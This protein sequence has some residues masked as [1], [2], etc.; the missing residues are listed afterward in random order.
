[1]AFPGDGI[2]P[3]VMTHALKALKALGEKHSVQLKVIETQC[4]SGYFKKTGR[5]WPEG[6]LD[7]CKEADAIILGAVGIPGVVMPDGKTPSSKVIFGLRLGLDLYANVR[8]VKLYPNVK[9]DVS[10]H[11]RR[12]W[13]SVDFVIVRE[14]TEGAYAPV[15]GNL[16]VGN[17][18]ERRVDNRLITRKGSERIARF[19]FG[20]ARTRNGSPLDG[21]RRVTCV[22]KSNVLA[23]CRLFRG[24][25]DE[26]ATHYPGIE[27]DYAYID[28]ITQWLVRRP[29]FYDV[30][31][32]TNLFGDILSDLAATLQGGM[33]MAPSAN[34]GDKHAM[35]E[36]VHGSAPDIAGKDVANPIAMLLSTK[37]MLEWL[38]E[39]KNDEALLECATDIESAVVKVLNEG[40]VLTPDLG[41]KSSCTDLGQEITKRLK[42]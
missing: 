38:G 37:M 8:P 23:G 31:V 17:Q 19:A 11:F 1:M 39:R 33:G 12:I 34:I 2:G 36:P 26:V 24:V 40:D 28:A 10:G 25:F 42:E 7:I 22:D 5:E 6:A 14:N 30:V 9:H 29:G 32:T 35:F 15:S 21:K 3:E 13:D 41:G 18:K 16:E 4:G 20:L 27:R